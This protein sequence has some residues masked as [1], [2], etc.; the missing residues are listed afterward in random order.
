MKGT[1]QCKGQVEINNIH[2]PLWP[3]LSVA[4]IYPGAMRIPGLNT[5]FPDEW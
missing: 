3:E 5:W 4:A 1:K 2:V